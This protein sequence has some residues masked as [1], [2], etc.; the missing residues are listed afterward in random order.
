MKL[1]M[2][3]SDAGGGCAMYYASVLLLTLILPLASVYVDRSLAHDGLPVL[4]L[5]GKW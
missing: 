4:L 2:L 5:V 3:I 1:V